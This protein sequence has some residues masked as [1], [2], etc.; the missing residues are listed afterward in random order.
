M[1]GQFL[2]TLIA[3]AG[4]R[5]QAVQGPGH[6]HPAGGQDPSRDAAAQR[7]FT[8]HPD[9]IKAIRTKLKRSQSGFAHMIGVS[10]ATLRNWEQGRRVPHGPARALLKVAA[11]RPKAIVEA[12]GR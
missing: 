7:T 4:L 6:E 9:D 2:R 1:T 8:F 12:L 11:M 5:A 10:V 3:R